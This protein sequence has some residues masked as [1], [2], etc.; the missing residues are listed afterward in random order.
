MALADLS[1]DTASLILRDE[2]LTASPERLFRY[3]TEPALLTRWWP[4]V[5]EVEP[6]TGG[7]Y[8]F[9]WP[10]AG[11]RLTG[12][13]T[14]FEPGR[15]LGFTWRWAHEPDAPETVGRLAFEAM[16]DGGM[17]LT[18]AHGPY[19]ESPE[20]QEMRAGHL[21]GWTHFLGRLHEAVQAG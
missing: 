7:S 3:W 4:Q 17:R 1:T 16:E 15:R 6:R 11:W 10:A 8:A 5:A 13:Y 12:H 2:F 21:E 14:I 18:L 19:D 20:S 9:S